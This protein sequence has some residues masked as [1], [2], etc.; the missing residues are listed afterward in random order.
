MRPR[1]RTMMSAVPIPKIVL[2]G[3][4]MIAMRIDSHSAL[5]AAGVVIQPHASANPCAK[6]FTNMTTTGRMSALLTSR[7][8]EELYVYDF[9][10]AAL[11]LADSLLT[12]TSPSSHISSPL[13]TPRARKHYAT[14]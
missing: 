11:A 5:I 13:A 6:V 4:A 8:A 2:R 1:R 9:L 7:Q 14:M 3:T 10:P 12:D